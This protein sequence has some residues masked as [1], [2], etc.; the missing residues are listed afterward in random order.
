MLG[1]VF[2]TSP[3]GNL[4]AGADLFIGYGNTV[5]L[6]GTGIIA[7]VEL[8]DSVDVEVA[9]DCVEIEELEAETD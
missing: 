3:C 9:F 1:L 5:G 4:V 7:A 2:E 6:R 8:G